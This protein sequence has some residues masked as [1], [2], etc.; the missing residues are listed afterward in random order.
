MRTII[1]IGM[2]NTGKST[3]ASNLSKKY[4]YPLIAPC[5]P[6]KTK[7]QMINHMKIA[8]MFNNV[9]Y[10]RYPVFEEMVYGKILRGKSKFN[11]HSKMFRKLRKQRTLIIYCRPDE[12]TIFNFGEREQMKGVISNSEKLLYSFDSLIDKLIYKYKMNVKI[13]DYEVDNWEDLI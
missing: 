5:G 7:K 10:E 3:L 4:R 8:Y 11:F 6:G 12:K 9:I 1:I 2:D 13:Y